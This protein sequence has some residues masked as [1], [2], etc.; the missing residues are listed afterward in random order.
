M[1]GKEEENAKGLVN[2]NIYDVGKKFPA[3]LGSVGTEQKH[4]SVLKPHASSAVAEV[5]PEL[6]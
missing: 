6:H 2:K 4:F 1:L 3:S 5:R